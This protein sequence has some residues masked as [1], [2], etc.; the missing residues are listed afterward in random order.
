M[1]VNSDCQH[2]HAKIYIIIAEVLL[3]IYFYVFSEQIV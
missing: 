2:A 1:L 3:H